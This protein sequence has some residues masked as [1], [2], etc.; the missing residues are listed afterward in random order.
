[1]LA[2]TCMA[3]PC[4]AIANTTVNR[5]D[6]FGMRDRLETRA[7][8]VRTVCDER[9]PFRVFV[10]ARI[11]ARQARTSSTIASGTVSRCLAFQVARSGT[12]R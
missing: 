8:V 3:G 4:P 5:Y 7:E 6:V 9:Y 12:R 1:M 2:I 10:W 11:A